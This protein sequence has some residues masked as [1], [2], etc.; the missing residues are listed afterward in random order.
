MEW[1]KMFPKEHQPSPE[2]MSSYIA[3]PLWE[4]LH[5]Y[6]DEAYG[7]KPEYSYSPLHSFMSGPVGGFNISWMTAPIVRAFGNDYDKFCRAMKYLGAVPEEIPDS[8]EHVWFYRI[9]PK[10]PMQIVYVDADDEFPCEVNLKLDNHAGQIMEFEQL[11][12][13]CGCFVSTL[14]GIG[15][16]IDP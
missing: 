16:T 11:A 4:K 1:Y 15:K 12:F 3:S 13:L 6:I 8:R 14:S 9:L 2:D 10:I 5:G 7:S